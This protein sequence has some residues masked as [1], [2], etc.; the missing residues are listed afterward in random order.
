MTDN[1]E[2]KLKHSDVNELNWKKSDY[3]VMIS[4]DW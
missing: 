4:A 2:T 1:L 3:I